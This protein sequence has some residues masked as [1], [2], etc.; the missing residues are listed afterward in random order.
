MR[1]ASHPRR[2][3]GSLAALALALAAA[4]LPASAQT[5]P[6]KPAVPPGR[7]PGGIAVAII[8]AGVD[9]RQPDIHARLAR[10]GEGEPIAWDVVDDDAKPLDSTPT[11]RLMPPHAASDA[12]RLLL[13]EAGATRLIPVRVPARN[14]LSAGGA[15]AFVARTPARVAAVLDA[16]MPGEPW[17]LFEAVA[18]ARPGL[19]IVVPAGH[20]GRDLDAEPAERLPAPVSLELASMLVVTATDADGRPHP[21]A[22]TGAKRV[23]IA[24]PVELPPG[25]PATAAEVEN[26][27]AVRVAALAA[28][29]LAVTPGLDAAGLKARLLS[30]AKPLPGGGAATRAGWLPDVARIDRL[31]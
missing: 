1:P 23:D 11:K 9:Y 19:V 22:S 27:A 2:A 18:K 12:A 14:A 29:M 24:V 31:E 13:A 7:D 26:R 17:P 3:C 6:R 15:L 10:D 4:I 25:R 30:H 20:V 16:G 28:R 5:G 21:A 8:G